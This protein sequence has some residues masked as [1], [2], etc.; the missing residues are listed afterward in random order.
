MIQEIPD[1]NKSPTQHI[2]VSRQQFL[3]TVIAGYKRIDPN[4]DRIASLKECILLT[5]RSV[6][7]LTHRS[8]FCYT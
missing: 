1:T 5:H 6:L 2:S 4:N 7:N 8:V 3:H